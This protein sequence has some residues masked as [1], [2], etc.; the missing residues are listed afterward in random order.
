MKTKLVF[1]LTLLTATPSFAIVDQNNN[2]LSDV[3]EFIYFG[4]PTEP[5]ADPDG[6]GVTTYD[7]MVWGTNPTNAAS[8]VTG[9]IS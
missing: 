8:K 7:E 6:D 9:P 4:G 5:F 2:G 1:A 3:Y